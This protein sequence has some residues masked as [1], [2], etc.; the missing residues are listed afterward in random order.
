[1][2]ASELVRAFGDTVL[3][4]VKIIATYRPV[5]IKTEPRKNPLV[6]LANG[7]SLNDTIAESLSVLKNSET[8]SVNFAPSTEVFFDIKPKYHVL[9]DPLFFSSDR[10]DNIEA[11][12]DNLARTDW[13]LT[14]FVPKK[15]IK[16]LPGAITSNRFIMVRTFNFCGVTGFKWFRNLVYGLKLA[17]PRPRNVLVPAIMCGIWSG[18]KT[19]YIAGADH[20]WM[21]T[22]S[23]DS[24]NNVISVQPHFYKDDKREQQRVD[25]TY[26]NYRLHDIV[27]SFYVAFRSYHTVSDFAKTKGVKI[28]NSTPGSFI[29][30]FERKAF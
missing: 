27:Y 24:N 22:I 4:C 7:P 26:R 13:N 16:N 21:Q 19:I 3:G 18:Y 25:T 1:M 6:I 8:M 11:M 15:F 10:P 29:D 14:L 12:F 9:A 30:A 28:F 20:S 23:V 2:K 5:D 17:M